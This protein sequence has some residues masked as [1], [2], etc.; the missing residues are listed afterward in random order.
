M[1]NSAHS[2]SISQIFDT[3]T[4]IEYAIPRYQREYTWGKTEIERI[5]DDLQEN[6]IGYFLGSIICINKS[7]DTLQVLELELVDGQQRLT[8]ITL[9]LAAAYQVLKSRESELDENQRFVLGTI[10]HQILQDVNNE[11][12]RLVLQVQ[13]NNLNDY[14]AVLAEIGIISN[15][16]LPAH[17]RLRKIYRA[18]KYFRDIA[19]E[20]RLETNF[21]LLNKVHGANLVKLKS[22]V[23]PMLIFY[24]NR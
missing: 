14:R 18:Y 20:N 3:N 1:I 21:E 6:D 12:T 17:F 16:D 11:K 23:T 2:Y 24:L 13:N 15:C 19:H 10:K 4:K 22:A 7:T 8:T 9:L 5:L